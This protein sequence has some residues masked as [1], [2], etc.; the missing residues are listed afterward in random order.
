MALQQLHYDLFSL[1]VP[2]LTN[3]DMICAGTSC[4]HIYQI[5]YLNN[6]CY[7]LWS[8]IRTT[9]HIQISR[10][11]IMIDDRDI[12]L[13]WLMSLFTTSR[14]NEKSESTNHTSLFPL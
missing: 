5:V 1:I 10:N 8:L 12:N 7:K 13:K 3:N 6:N 4:R 14:L 11:E 2:Y 9:T